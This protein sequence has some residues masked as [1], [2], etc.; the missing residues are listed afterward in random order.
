MK[1]MYE[2]IYLYA[3]FLVQSIQTQNATT[4]KNIF[5]DFPRIN[6]SKTDVK[7]NHKQFMKF[8]KVTF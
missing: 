4:I 8:Q 3:S 7:Q 2:H 6:I 5:N 1:S